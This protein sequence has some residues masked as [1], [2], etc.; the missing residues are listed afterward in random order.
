MGKVFQPIRA[1]VCGTME[2]PSLTEVLEIIGKEETIS[3]LSQLD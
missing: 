1:G 2:S 3:R